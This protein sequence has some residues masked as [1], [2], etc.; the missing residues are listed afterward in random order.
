MTADPRQLVMFPDARP[1][2]RDAEQARLAAR[3]DA[4]QALLRTGRLSQAQVE[5][6]DAYE[7]LTSL[8]R[9]DAAIHNIYT[10]SGL[11]DSSTGTVIRPERRLADYE[12]Q[13]L[14]LDTYLGRTI[15]F[16]PIRDALQ[17]WPVLEFGVDDPD[18]ED[19]HELQ[20]QASA[21]M[22]E[23]ETKGREAIV[24]AGAYARAFGGAIVY[25]GV[26]DGRAP[27]QPVDETRISEVTHFTVFQP[28]ELMVVGIENDPL[29]PNYRQ[30]TH[31][32]IQ[33]Q[34]ASPSHR[35][36]LGAN[37]INTV[38]HASR[39]VQFRGA[40]TTMERYEYNQYWDDS[41]FQSISEVLKRCNIGWQT[42]SNLLNKASLLVL[43]QEGYRQMI[44]GK[45][46]GGMSLATQLAILRK[47][48]SVAG[49]LHMDVKDEIENISVQMTGVPDMVDRLCSEAAAATGIPVTIL[50]GV[51]PAGQNATG[52]SDWANYM[53]FLKSIQEW[54]LDRAI[55]KIAE[56]IML[57]KL[58][59]IK[60]KLP[61][62]WWVKFQ[63]TLEPTDREQAEI[64]KLDSETFKNYVESELATPAEISTSVFSEQGYTRD[65]KIDEESRETQLELDAG[66]MEL[67]GEQGPQLPPS[68]PGMDSEDDEENAD[69]DN[70]PD[71]EADD[72]EA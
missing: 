67:L 41:I 59:P 6:L 10:G 38:I 55:R 7:A 60:G 35:Y 43:R 21:V 57:A 28:T 47:S 11:V 4:Q 23:V 31:Y 5:H 29:A 54:D 1:P 66:Q 44:A 16:R 58:G 45:A 37:R 61:R 56:L 14:L 65:I 15:C 24:R 3:R 2:V 68:P 34:I 39:C 18:A 50:W 51:S 52:E 32:Q 25:A 70:E 8:P 49:A 36:G 27:D 30:P 71:D 69:D 63:R 12:I 26:V 46:S 48:L 62:R 64:R 19:V 40:M 20:Q 42:A 53:E 13:A 17:R 9:L 22:D 33:R 72:S